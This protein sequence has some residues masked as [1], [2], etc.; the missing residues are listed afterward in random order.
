MMNCYVVSLVLA[1]FS[2]PGVDANRV[3]L[4]TRPIVEQLLQD[5]GYALCDDGSGVEVRIL[6]VKSPTRGIQI[7]PFKIKQKKTIVIT[8]I[9][10]DGEKFVGEGV[11]K[12]SARS[13][14]TQLKDETLPLNETAFSVALKASIVDALD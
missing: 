8:E 4:G 14:I 7:G 13:T 2:I 11:S 6:E 12:T 1:L 10:I 9:I 5:N 3:Q